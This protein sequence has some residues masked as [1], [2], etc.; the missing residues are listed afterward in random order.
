MLQPLGAFKDT[1]IGDSNELAVY[2]SVN[3]RSFIELRYLPFPN[4]SPMAIQ[5]EMTLAVH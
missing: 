3:R 5:E 4:S 2:K 1:E